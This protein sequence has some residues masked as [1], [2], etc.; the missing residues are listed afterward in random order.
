MDALPR[1]LFRASRLLFILSGLLIGAGLVCVI[2]GGV[3]GAEIADRLLARLMAE[4]DPDTLAA[5]P[6]DFLTAETV[7]RAATAL[8][9][10]LLLLGA[11]QLATS[12]GLRRRQ[13]W[14]Y[15]AA[16]VGGLFV[17]FTAGASAVF[18]VVA[19]ASQPQAT[20]PLAVGAV[21]LAGVAILYA[22]I[23]IW[24]AGGRR[25]LEQSGAVGTVD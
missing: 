19:I 5:L 24:T 18:M 17:A 16:V 25:T 22:A 13:R 15:A 20:I 4:I 14:S 21:V 10:G 3:G 1:P 12:I 23:A 7:I 8:G 9:G 6:P 11:A 2:G